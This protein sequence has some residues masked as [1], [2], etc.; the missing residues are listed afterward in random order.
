MRWMETIKI[1]SAT[2]KEQITVNEL[3]ALAQKVQ[4][5]ANG[6]VLRDAM[7]FCHASVPG[8]FALKLFWNTDTAQ[9]RGSMIGLSLTQALEAFG[10]VDRSVWIEISQTKGGK[11][12]EQ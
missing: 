11:E 5:S 12:D 8:Y 4:K 9:T 6:Q 1:Q 3:I 10:L 7:V 2:G